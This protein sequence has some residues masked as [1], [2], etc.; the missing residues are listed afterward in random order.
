MTSA[1]ILMDAWTALSPAEQLAQWEHF[2]RD[3]DAGEAA[4][5]RYYLVLMPLWD[6]G[7][8]PALISEAQ[9]QK[10]EAEMVAEAMWERRQ[11]PRSDAWFDYSVAQ[12]NTATAAI[13]DLSEVPF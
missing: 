8:V 12:S 7:D 2:T 1:N 10:L 3:L 6:R 5:H 13:I 4:F 9:L 11:L